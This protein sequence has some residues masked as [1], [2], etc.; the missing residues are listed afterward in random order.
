MNEDY[1]AVLETCHKVFVYANEHKWEALYKEVFAEK[2]TTDDSSYPGAPQAVTHLSSRLI[3]NWKD[4][5]TRIPFARHNL[6][7]E[8]ITISGNAANVHV[9]VTGIHMK[10]DPEDNVLKWIVY[11][12]YDIALQKTAAGWRVTAMKQHFLFQEGS[13][14]LVI[15]KA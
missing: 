11:S 14:S 1:I 10:R 4:V 12:T 13:P 15:S 5:F 2:V 9:Y 3:D 8:L 7:N 6:S